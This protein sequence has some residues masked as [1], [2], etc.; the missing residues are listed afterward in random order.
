[1]FFLAGR[2]GADIGISRLQHIPLLLSAMADESKADEATAATAAAQAEGEA[3]ALRL[4]LASRALG[5][6]PRRRRLNL[7]SQV[8]RHGPVAWA[9]G[10]ATR[11]LSGRS[12]SSLV[13]SRR[14]GRVKIERS[15]HGVDLRGAMRPLRSSCNS[16]SLTRPLRA[17]VHGTAATHGSGK[18]RNRSS[19]MKLLSGR[20]LAPRGI[21]FFGVASVLISAILRL[22]LKPSWG[23]RSR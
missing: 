19:L 17:T 4:K 6:P 8:G 9:E 1:M 5:Y 18:C 13:K 3:G 12:A 15:G 16:S 20:R 22:I 23:R 10:K 21:G 7:S 11:S 14:L 2:F